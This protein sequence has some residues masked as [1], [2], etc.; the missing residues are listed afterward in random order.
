LCI[1]ILSGPE[2]TKIKDVERYSG[3]T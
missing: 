1:A 2:H 3:D